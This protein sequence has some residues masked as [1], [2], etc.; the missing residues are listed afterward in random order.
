MYSNHDPLSFEFIIFI[1]IIL[2]HLILSFFV[3]HIHME[4]LGFL[5]IKLI[6]IPENLTAANFI[7]QSFDY[8]FKYQ[9]GLIFLSSE[10]VK[11]IPKKLF[12]FFFSELDFHM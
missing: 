7:L 12:S 9:F 4:V 8:I 6:F 3:Q 11:G 5:K 2:I 1:S 10:L